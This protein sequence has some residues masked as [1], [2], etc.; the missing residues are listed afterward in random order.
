MQ[1]SKNVYLIQINLAIKTKLVLGL[2]NL[3]KKSDAHFTNV[4]N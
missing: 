2:R 3:H 1:Y 4:T